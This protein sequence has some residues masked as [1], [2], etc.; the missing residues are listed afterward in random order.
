MRRRLRLLIAIAIKLALPT[1]KLD[2]EAA[3]LFRQR[4]LLYSELLP[5]LRSKHLDRCPVHIHQR[6]Y[7]VWSS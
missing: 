5:K 6:G 4:R 1:L 2:N 7:R 3:K